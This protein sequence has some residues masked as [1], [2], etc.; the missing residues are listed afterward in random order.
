[1]VSAKQGDVASMRVSKSAIGPSWSTST[2]PHKV[3]AVEVSKGS[4]H[5]RI[6]AMGLLDERAK[7]V[8]GHRIH[9]SQLAM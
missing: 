6:S 4:Q 1:M 2:V 7:V 9:F 8:S 5:Q 3:G